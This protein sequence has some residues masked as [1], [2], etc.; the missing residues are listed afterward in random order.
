[1]SNAHQFV[2]L[3]SGNIRS[4]RGRLAYTQN[5]FTPAAMKNDDGTPQLDKNGKPVLKHQVTIVFPKNTDFSLLQAEIEKTA[6]AKW[7]EDYKKKV[8]VKKP[9]LKTEDYPKMGF[10]PEEFPVFIRLSCG[11][12]RPPQIARADKT[13]VTA[14]QA[15]DVYS[16]RWAYVSLNTYATQHPKGGARVS[17]GWANLQLLDHDEPVGGAPRVA[18]DEEFEAVETTE[19][20]NGSASDMFDD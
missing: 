16:G 10:D 3:P 11:D 13:L 5:V 2:K 4:A 1:M 12:D 6:I 17:A 19:A 20:G 15:S 18:A 14:A 7:G 8:G 9:F